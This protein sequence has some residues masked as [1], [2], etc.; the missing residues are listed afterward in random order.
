M[1]TFRHFRWDFC[2]DSRDLR[3]DPSS[4]GRESIVLEQALRLLGGNVSFT[5]LDFD[6]RRYIPVIRGE[7][8]GAPA[9]LVL[10]GRVV[11]GRS[12]NQLPIFEQYYIGGTETVRGYNNEQQFGD[13]QL[14]GNAELRYRFQN[15]V[16]GVLF[17]DS[18]TAYGGQFS[19]GNDINLLTSFGVGVRLVTPIGPIRLDYGIGR[20]GG[21]TH[22]GI[23]ST[24]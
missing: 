24:F 5:K 20:D 6:L 2:G 11:L 17:A 1:A 13:N 18:G 3:I 16:T 14:Y 15:K 22:F 8:T 9:K 19:T 23:G 12:I 4:G 10:A 7:K 21:R